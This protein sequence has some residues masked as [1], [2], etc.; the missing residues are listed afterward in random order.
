VVAGGLLRLAPAALTDF[1]LNDGG[2]FSEMIDE[3]RENHF[4]LPPFTSYNQAEIPFAY[5]P[6]GFYLAAAVTSMGVST[7]DALIWLPA[8][9]CILTIPA[10]YFMSRAIMATRMPGAV[11]TALFA[12]TP[13]TMIWF[14]MGGGLTRS[15]GLL[16]GLLTI[17]CYAR[18]CKAEG[19]KHKGH[20]VTEREDLLE[21]VPFGWLGL[22][23]LCGG[24][25]VMSHLE[26]GLMT[27]AAIAV[28]LLVRYRTWRALGWS[29]AAAG[30]VMLLS[31]P[32]WAT[33]V[34]RFG[35]APFLSAA[36]TSSESLGARLQTLLYLRVP[37]EPL[38]PLIAAL[39]LLGIFACIARRDWLLP[40]WYVMALL[41]DPRG[42]AFAA[43][44]FIMMASV[45]LTELVIPGVEALA[46]RHG[47]IGQGMANPVVRGLIYL[48]ALGLVLNAALTSAAV[49]A[50]DLPA[51]DRE[52]MDWVRQNTPEGSRFLVLTGN[53]SP[54]QDAVTEWFPALAGRMNLTTLQGTEWTTG[55]GFWPLL[56]AITRVQACWPQ[57]EACLDEYTARLGGDYDFVYLERRSPEYPCPEQ[58]ELCIT[59]QPLVESLG[60]KAGTVYESEEVLILGLE[61]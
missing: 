31:A 6:L 59:S 34:T 45:A 12:L 26:A 11:A 4:A 43:L 32:W 8:L 25:T 3:L 21:Q 35:L 5:P 40:A 53:L 38:F 61:E 28:I 41:V 55:S 50:T 37:E 10:F 16:L 17:G 2:M 18:M 46:V 15:L 13:R 14:L 22:T 54:M 58:R 60:D 27:A 44:P 24:L 20:Q 30:G 19:A 48:V 39:G 7:A 36:Q 47:R 56:Q 52:A 33:V 51:S 29:L 42:L 49:R 1:P 23:I 9:L 57:D